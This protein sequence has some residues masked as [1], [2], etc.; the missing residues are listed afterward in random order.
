MGYIQDSLSN[1]EEVRDLFKLHWFAKIW[2]IIWIIL[3]THY[4]NNSDLC[5]VG[6]AEI[7]QHRARGHKQTR[8][9]QEGDYQ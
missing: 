4:R 5:P 6:V 9:S 2:M 1:G 7:A 8:H 3:A